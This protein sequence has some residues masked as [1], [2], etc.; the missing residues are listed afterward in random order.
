MITRKRFLQASVITELTLM[1]GWI[2]MNYQKIQIEKLLL[3]II[4]SLILVAYAE[5]YRR[6]LIASLE[7]RANDQLLRQAKKIQLELY[8]IVLKKDWTPDQKDALMEMNVAFQKVNPW[9]KYSG[10]SIKQKKE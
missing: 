1:L 4:C 2:L 8:E 7:K 6:E 10:K 3:A 5:C 9:T